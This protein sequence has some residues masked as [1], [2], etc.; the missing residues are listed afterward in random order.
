MS[1]AP[2]CLQTASYAVSHFPLIAI[3]RDEARPPRP[4]GVDRAWIDWLTDGIPKIGP[5]S[6][7]RG[8]GIWEGMRTTA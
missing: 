1:E 8:V 3:V 6:T 7:L 2:G 5:P 4:D